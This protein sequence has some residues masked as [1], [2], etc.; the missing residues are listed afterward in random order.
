MRKYFAFIHAMRY[1]YIMY[2]Y[3]V[4]WGFMSNP[5]RH[6]FLL[7][8]KAVSHKGMMKVNHINKCVSSNPN[9]TSSDRLTKL[10]FTASSLIFVPVE[11]IKCIQISASLLSRAVILHEF[12]NSY[13]PQPPLLS[14]GNNN[15]PTSL[16]YCENKII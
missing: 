2:T 12:C 14:N 1:L 16:D 3:Y 9:V 11:T 6:I 5:V 10:V 15:S 13:L 8:N 7:R 4:S